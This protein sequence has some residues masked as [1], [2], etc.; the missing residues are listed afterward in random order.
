DGGR[1]KRG[2]TEMERTQGEA[3]SLY[4]VP[5]PF[6][7]PKGGRHGRAVRQGGPCAIDGKGAGLC[8]IA[9]RLPSQL[10]TLSRKVTASFE[11]RVQGPRVK[12]AQL[13]TGAAA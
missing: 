9:V 1:E 7:S 4:P 3:L 11:G 10:R 8:A 5:G 6:A 2:D 12:A 13:R